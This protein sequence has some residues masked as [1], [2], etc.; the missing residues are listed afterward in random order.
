VTSFND[1]DLLACYAR[2]RNGSR[3]FHAA[4]FLLPRHARH[5]AAALYAF[6]RVADDA[7]DRG[8]ADSESLEQ[9]RD[10]LAR[11]YAGDPIDAPEDRM[12]AV[13]VRNYGIP[14]VI[15]E[16]L[17]E[18]FAWD[19]QGRRYDSIEDLHAYAARVAGTVGAMMA[20]IMGV[21]AP[22]LIARACELGMAMQLTNIARDVGE[23]ARAGR[24]YLPRQWLQESGVDPDQWLEYP[25]NSAAVGNVVRRVLLAAEE[26]Y[27]RADPGISK[28]PLGCRV[29]IRSARLIYADIGREIARA[30][31]DSVTRRAIVPPGR[32]ARL[33]GRALLSAGA[34]GKLIPTQALDASRFLVEAV[35]DHASQQSFSSFDLSPLWWEFDKRVARTLDLFH[36]L[37][38][39][40]RLHRK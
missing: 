10:R 8:G 12:F 3:S 29:G 35:A 37:E 33:I 32:K 34:S 23:D 24:L 5:P 38:Q 15:P 21:R 36:E 25:V 6:C 11:I 19:L 7:I 39:R 14:K 1:P 40:E 27:E 17:L 28:L 20:I 18:G 2:L 13:V 22:A 4:S 16:A 30:G 26:L 9:I 31:M